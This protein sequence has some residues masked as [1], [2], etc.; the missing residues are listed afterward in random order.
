MASSVVSCF[1]AFE[2]MDGHQLTLP[3][4]GWRPLL[5]QSS[6]VQSNVCLP[7]TGLMDD[8][9]VR[10]LS[11]MGTIDCI[12]STANAD[13]CEAMDDCPGVAV[14]VKQD[15]EGQRTP[16]ARISSFHQSIEMTEACRYQTCS[17]ETDLRAA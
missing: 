6:V 14:P 4:L 8:R 9:V 7:L 16:L 12:A 15:P 11:G 5:A 3:S 1:L 2:Q 17:E 13:T 10:V